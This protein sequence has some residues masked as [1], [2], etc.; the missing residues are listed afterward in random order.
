MEK[1][2]FRT[3]RYY[4]VVIVISLWNMSDYYNSIRTL[5]NLAL[6]LYTF[7]QYNSLG[8][9]WIDLN[10]DENDIEIEQC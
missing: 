6:V 1:I 10:T 4:I 7:Y 5:F 3:L 2:V 8:R 9:A